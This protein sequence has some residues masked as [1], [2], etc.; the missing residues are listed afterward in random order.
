ML[1]LCFFITL[2]AM[3]LPMPAIALEGPLV[4]LHMNVGQGDATLIIAPSGE[5]ILFDG[6]DK[7]TGRKVVTAR[8]RTLGYEKIDY[9]IASHY[10]ADHIGG[11]DDAGR[12][13]TQIPVEVMDRRETTPLGKKDT[14]AYD[15]YASVFAVSRSEPLTLGPGLF[16]FASELSVLVV[17]GNGCVYGQSSVEEPKL[18]ENASSLSIVLNYGTFD[19]FIGGDLT[20]GGRTG[21]RRTADLE[22]PVAGVVGRVDVLRLNHHGSETSSNAGFL[23]TLD[24][25][26]AII[27]VGN[28]GSNKSRYKHPRRSVLD[29]LHEIAGIGNLEKVYLTNRGE[30]DGG[31]KSRDEALLD[32]VDGDIAV[33]SNGDWFLV[34]GVAY[35]TDSKTSGA[36]RFV[37]QASQ[38]CEN[39]G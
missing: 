35:H 4:I 28:G 20:G 2:L 15:D 22:T 34:N 23:G 18:D 37:G 29:R 3:L 19:Y 32:I 30:T 25:K 12:L 21:S 11:L 33:V 24:P 6:G 10:D 7:T 16:R 1:K 13:L 17:S 39:S 27:S 36:V 5:T 14:R 8:L 31:L 26:V 9:V 38:I